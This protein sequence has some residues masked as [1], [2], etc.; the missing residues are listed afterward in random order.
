LLEIDECRITPEL[1]L[2]LTTRDNL[3]VPVQ[4]GREDQERFAMKPE[5][6][7]VLTE[8]AQEV[9][10]FK[11]TEDKLRREVRLAAHDRIEVVS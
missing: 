11:R 6:V 10:V 3:A 7:S 2:Q 4:K 5:G 1:T 9:V 8:L